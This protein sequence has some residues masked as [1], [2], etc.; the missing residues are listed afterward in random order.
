MVVGTGSV[1]GFSLHPSQPHSSQNNEGGRSDRSGYRSLRRCL[2]VMMF[3]NLMG[4]RFG[5]L[6][7]PSDGGGNDAD[8]DDVYDHD[9][10]MKVMMMLMMMVKG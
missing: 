2:S 7:P 3:L 5:S 6:G 10:E 8:A 4:N 9:N 1:G